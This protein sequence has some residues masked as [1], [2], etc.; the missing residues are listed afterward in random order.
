MDLETTKNLTYHAELHHNTETQ[1]GGKDCYRVR[2]NGRVKTWKTRPNEVA[3]P[4]KWGFRGPYDCITELNM[5][6]WHLE[7]ECKR[8]A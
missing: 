1:N 7:S 2:V 6:D 4:V 8:N 5:A 3:V